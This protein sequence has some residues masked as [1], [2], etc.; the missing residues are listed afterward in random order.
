MSPDESFVRF[1]LQSWNKIIKK[2]IIRV[3]DKSHKIEH[4]HLKIL[5]ATMGSYNIT[6]LNQPLIP[7]F[8]IFGFFS[9]VSCNDSRDEGADTGIQKIQNYSLYS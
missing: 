5:L 9:M 7:N 6:Q 8:E 4:V 1:I 3:A 2:I